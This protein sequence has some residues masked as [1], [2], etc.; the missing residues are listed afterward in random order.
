VGDWE[1]GRDGSV[2]FAGASRDTNGR[3]GSTLVQTG[4]ERK[5]INI[6]Y[7][8]SSN[9]NAKVNLCAYPAGRRP[10]VVA[11]RVRSI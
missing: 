5:A 9:S 2:T 11:V 4:K 7:I 8:Y 6:E 3:G 10:V 1:S